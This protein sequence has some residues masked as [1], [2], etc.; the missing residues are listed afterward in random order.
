MSSL[1]TLHARLLDL[2]RRE[3]GQGTTEY[4]V[5]LVGVIAIAT[6]VTAALQTQLVTKLTSI[7]SG[8]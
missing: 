3:E 4:V 7:I 6:A 5:L 1:L 2:L 8:I